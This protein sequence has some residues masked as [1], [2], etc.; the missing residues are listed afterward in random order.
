MIK[1]CSCCF[2]RVIYT[3]S[4]HNSWSRP[5]QPW[6][7]MTLPMDSGSP[8]PCPASYQLILT[9]PWKTMKVIKAICSGFK[10]QSDILILYRYKWNVLIK[11]SRS[12]MKELALNTIYI[13]QWLL[14]FD[15]FVLFS[16]LPTAWLFHSQPACFS[17]CWC[18][19]GQY[20]GNHLNLGW[21]PCPRLVCNHRAFKSFQHEDPTVTHRERKFTALQ[22]DLWAWEGQAKAKGGRLTG[23]K[24][25]K[26][27]MR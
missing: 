7:R 19:C 6:T 26:K 9:S 8:S 13:K 3:V 11:K 25:G 5:S 10:I 12:K 15:M 4:G 14:V 23:I 24:K 17:S 16:G 2:W 1:C 21:I 27:S 18:Q 20:H 22:M